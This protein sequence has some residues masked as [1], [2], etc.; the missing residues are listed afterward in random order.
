MV[1]SHMQRV[2]KIV[3]PVNQADDDALQLRH[4]EVEPLLGNISGRTVF[5]EESLSG[6]G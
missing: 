1:R 4:L 2:H 6:C 3:L 5:G